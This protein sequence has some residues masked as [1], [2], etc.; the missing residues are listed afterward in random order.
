MLP[1]FRRAHAR[2]HE[3]AE[4][5]WSGHA[6]GTWNLLQGSVVP[7]PADA[8]LAPLCV[9]DP[10]RAYRLAAW[11]TAGAVLGGCVA[12]LIGATAYDSVGLRLL[13]WAGIERATI[14]SRRA[15]FAQHGWQM[16]V[17]SAVSPLPTKIVS[18]AAGAFAVSPW[19]FVLSLLLGRAARFG[20][21][22][23]VCRVLGRRLE[24]KAA[25]SGEPLANE[26]DGGKQ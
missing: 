3:W 8:L 13:D 4:A 5:G 25:E 17:L 18:L 15:L 6:V 24:R 23:A 21:V 2:L 10:P 22:A 14:E 11:A 12:Y 20:V 26:S 7:G 19:A 1:V 9:S 16:V